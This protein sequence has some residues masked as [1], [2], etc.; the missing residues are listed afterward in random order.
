MRKIYIAG[1]TSLNKK[2][3]KTVERLARSMYRGDRGDNVVFIPTIGPGDMIDEIRVKKFLLD[4]DDM[5]VV[6]FLPD[7]KDDWVAKIEHEHCVKTKKNMAYAKRVAGGWLLQK[8]RWIDE[9]DT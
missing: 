8:I 6:V 3:T 9:E 4:I 7:W 5:D 1:N 2:H